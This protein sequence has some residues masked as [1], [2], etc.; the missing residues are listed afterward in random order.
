MGQRFAM[1]A[2]GAGLPIVL[3]LVAAPLIG[4]YLYFFQHESPGVIGA[5]MG[6][7]A[8]VATVSAVWGAAMKGKAIEVSDVGIA[9]PRLWSKT[10]DVIEWSWI[11]LCESSL[12]VD[13]SVGRHDYL[14]IRYWGG[15][16]RRIEWGD[17]VDY[18]NLER[19]ILAAYRQHKQAETAKPA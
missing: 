18:D 10:P 6:G 9:F 12:H 1:N 4:L 15:R 17:V 2:V 5:V 19:V 8:V 7:V 16:R 14:E 13:S 11:E 3:G